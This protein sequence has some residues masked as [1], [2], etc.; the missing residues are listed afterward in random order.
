MMLSEI[1]SPELGTA[2]ADAVTTWDD[3]E[4]TFP[5]DILLEGSDFR[6]ISRRLAAHRLGGDFHTAV[7]RESGQIVLALGGIPVESADAELAKLSIAAALRRSTPN[8]SLQRTIQDSFQR[9]LRELGLLPAPTSGPCSI[10]C[11]RVDRTDRTLSFLNRGNCFAFVLGGPGESMMLTAA[12][13]AD[14]EVAVASPVEQD[15][16]LEEARRVIVCTDGVFSARSAA[17]EA[18]GKARLQ[19]LVDATLNTPLE[20]QV[21]TI[22]SAV[23]RH[24]GV[25]RPLKRDATVLAADFADER[26]L[27][28]DH[29]VQTQVG[30]WRHGSQQPI[31]TSVYLG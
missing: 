29:F 6:V 5:P 10:F 23:R 31:E 26:T 28:L 25:D 1:L 27:F 12:D 21:E 30:L 22:L 9:P 2:A 19:A 8:L 16:S 15:I 11:A 13:E 20:D 14:V 17:G 18:F 7:I 3:L 4:S 24:V